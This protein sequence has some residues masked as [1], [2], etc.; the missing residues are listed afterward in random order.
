[1][2]SAAAVAHDNN[3]TAANAA[4]AREAKDRSTPSIRAG[5]PP[6]RQERKQLPLQ[7]ITLQLR[8]TGT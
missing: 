6:S 5:S 2:L 1:M 8:T 4:L 3:D 7:N